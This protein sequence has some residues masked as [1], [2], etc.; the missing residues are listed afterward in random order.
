[1]KFIW[2]SMRKFCAFY[3]EIQL[4]AHNLYATWHIIYYCSL[5]AFCEFATGA[6]RERAGVI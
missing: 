4:I 6:V 1:M 2:N 3:A 5:L